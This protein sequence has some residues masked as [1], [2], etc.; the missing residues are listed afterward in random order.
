M[1][2]AAAHQPREFV[3]QPRLGEFAHLPRQLFALQ[4]RQQLFANLQRDQRKN[5]SENL[6]KLKQKLSRTDAKDQPRL[7]NILNGNHKKQKSK[8]C[9]RSFQREFITKLASSRSHSQL[10]QKFVKNFFPRESKLERW[11][12][13]FHKAHRPKWLKSVNQESIKRFAE[14]S[15]K[16]PVLNMLLNAN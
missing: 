6:P 10:L 8:L 3:P 4:H 5:A 9:N 11:S 1:S 13:R 15:L 12:V 16:P 7:R 2:P 14:K